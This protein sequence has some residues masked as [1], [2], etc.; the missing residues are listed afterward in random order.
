MKAILVINPQNDFVEAYPEGQAV[1]EII[2]DYLIDNANFNTE[3]FS[4]Q[5]TH[6]EMPIEF[7]FPYPIIGS[8]GHDIPP[9]VSLALYDTRNIY[10]G[11]HYIMKT[12][13]CALEAI[14]LMKAFQFDEVIIMGFGKADLL[15]TAWGVKEVFPQMKISFVSRAITFDLSVDKLKNEGWGVIE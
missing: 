7:R 3:V 10:N 6:Y 4:V 9:E 12:K 14:N 13:P 1:A 15:L 8:F 2:G 5:D 11:I